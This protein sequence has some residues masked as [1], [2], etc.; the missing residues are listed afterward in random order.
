M[1]ENGVKSFLDSMGHD[2]KLRL[3]GAVVIIILA[4]AALS[5]LLS[6]GG[7]AADRCMSSP[8]IGNRYSCIET[9]AFATGNSTLCSS[10]PSATAD[11]CYGAMA[12]NLSDATLCGKISD[13]NASG[14]CFESLAIAT[15]NYTLCSYAPQAVKDSCLMTMSAASNSSAICDGISDPLGRSECSSS[16]YLSL[17]VKS[18][19]VSYC[20]SVMQRSNYSVTNRIVSDAAASHGANL[21]LAPILNYYEFGNV[22]IGARDFCIASV[23]YQ[24][25]NLSYCSGAG[26][27]TAVGI[28]ASLVNDTLRSSSQAYGTIN[29]TQLIYSCYNSTGDYQ[30]CN[31]TYMSLKAISTG[32][33][34]I[35]ATLPTNYS[36]SCYSS[37]AQELNDSVYCSYIKN[38][39]V[40]SACYTSLQYRNTTVT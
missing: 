33:A 17:A 11:Q 23:A 22:T 19:N 38:G 34:T 2:E 14:S 30:S 1:E 36:Y 20:S 25:K 29:Y 35:C 39:T 10:L 5:F 8:L 28:C 31:S 18:G 7:S 37:L 13:S 3:Y 40:S 12:Q 9:L 26:N 4:L 16:I 15:G 21:T 32:N 6:P 27:G 24:S